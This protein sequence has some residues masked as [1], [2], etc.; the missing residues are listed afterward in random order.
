[1][2]PGHGRMAFHHLAAVTPE[3]HS[4][5]NSVVHPPSG[6]Y[7]NGAWNRPVSSRSSTIPTTSTDTSVTSFT[8]P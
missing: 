8:A 1:M 6:S 4:Q 3:L 5:G 7:Q 2:G